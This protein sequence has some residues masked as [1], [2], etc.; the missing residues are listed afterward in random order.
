MDLRNAVQ[1]RLERA[2]SYQAPA[3]ANL[4]MNANLGDDDWEV[5]IV[6]WRDRP[7]KTYSTQNDKEHFGHAAVEVGFVSSPASLVA[8]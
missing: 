6:L 2:S 8:L 7:R 5:E 4:Y 1:G 3:P